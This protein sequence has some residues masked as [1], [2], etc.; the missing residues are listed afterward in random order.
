VHDTAHLHVM[1]LGT[2]QHLH[3]PLY[4]ARLPLLTLPQAHVREYMAA[5]VDRR[6]SDTVKA[7][8]HARVRLLRGMP[9]VPVTC[10]TTA[11]RRQRWQPSAG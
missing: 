9:A 7:A 5:A 8:S 11:V 6:A 1:V 2:R 3:L 10:A 4:S